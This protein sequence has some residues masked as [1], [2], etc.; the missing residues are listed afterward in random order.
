[1]NNENTVSIWRLPVSCAPS[2]MEAIK[3]ELHMAIDTNEF[4]KVERLVDIL[5]DLH[6]ELK[7]EENTEEGEE[8]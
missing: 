1:M 7:P 4:G 8:E 5:K 2:V 3:Y 6:S